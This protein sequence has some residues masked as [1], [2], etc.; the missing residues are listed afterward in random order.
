MDIIT[1]ILLLSAAIIFALAAIGVATARIS[2]I[3][4][5]LL[6]WILVP[7]INHIETLD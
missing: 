4:L 6:L 3:P 7:L 1:L 5:G 2:L